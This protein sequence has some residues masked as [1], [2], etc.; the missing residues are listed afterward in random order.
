[1]GEKKGRCSE[2]ALAAGPG[3]QMPKAAGN[4]G[5][6]T[7]RKEWQNGCSPGEGRKF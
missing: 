3:G 2:A 7:I 5:G 6:T 4:R 1:M